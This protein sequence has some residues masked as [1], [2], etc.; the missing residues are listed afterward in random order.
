[1]AGPLRNTRHERFCVAYAQGRS[2]WEA[3]G[4][5]GYK[6]QSAPSNAAAASRLLTNVKIC[7]RI[8]ELQTI[9]AAESITAAALTNDW[10][11]ER[12]IE[13]A[14]EAMKAGQRAPANTALQ[15]L[16]TTRRM[17]TTLTESTVNRGDAAS[18]SLEGLNARLNQLE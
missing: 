5:A 10:I 18:M 17:F 13:N 2:A 3:Y 6:P 9:L 8:I 16:G 4:L 11:I 12:L 15:L 7:D 1:M 14:V